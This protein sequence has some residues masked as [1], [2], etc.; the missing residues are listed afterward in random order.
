[1]RGRYYLKHTI[2]HL[3]SSG[4]NNRGYKSSLMEN[5]LHYK[6]YLKQNPDATTEE[7]ITMLGYQNLTDTEINIALMMSHDEELCKTYCGKTI[8][9]IKRDMDK[10]NIGCLFTLVFFIFIIICIIKGV[11]LN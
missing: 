8:K 4:S 1:M 2:N 11:F 10:K 5:V 9:E 7:K 6:N 3:V